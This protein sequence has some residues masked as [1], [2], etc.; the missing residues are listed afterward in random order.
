MQYVHDVV[1][2]SGGIVKVISVE[3]LASFSTTRSSLEALQGID[4]DLGMELVNGFT[5]SFTEG[6]AGSVDLYRL[7]LQ[8]I[9][10]GSTD[11]S[12]WPAAAAKFAASTPHGLK[13]GRTDSNGDP[14]FSVY[15]ALLSITSAASSV[16]IN[17]DG[18]VNLI[19]FTILSKQWLQAP[20]DPSADIAP[21]GGDG[22]VDYL[23]LDVLTEQWLE[24]VVSD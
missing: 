1:I 7:T 16:D 12:I 23:D 20:G 3:P 15:P 13:V 19:D 10:E 24:G 21:D 2:D 17:C 18:K 6:L 14:N 5:T 9:G 4:G 8:V 11:V 22:V